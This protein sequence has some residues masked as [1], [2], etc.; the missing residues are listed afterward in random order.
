MART[1]ARQRS[2]YAW[3]ASICLGLGSLLFFA[4]G[5]GPWVSP[6]RIALL[7]TSVAA[8]TLEARRQRHERRRRVGRP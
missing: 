8:F 1:P 7:V 4:S 3:T 6:L 5:L 2:A